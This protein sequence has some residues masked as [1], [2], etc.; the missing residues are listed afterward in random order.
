VNV[1]AHGSGLVMADAKST[2]PAGRASRA[3]PATAAV[4]DLEA[5]PD[6]VLPLPKQHSMSAMGTGKMPGSEEP[7]RRDLETSIPAELNTVLAFYRNELGKRGW[8]EAAERALV[9]PDQVQ[10]AF[11]APDGPALLKLGRS[12]DE[13]SVKLSQKYPGSAAKANLIP[14]PG[15]ARLVFANMGDG[16]VALSINKQT[17]KIAAGAGGPQSPARPMLDLPP[18]KYPYSVKVAGRP[19]RNDTIEVAA[20]DAWGV[21]FAPSGEALSLQVY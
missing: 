8:K 13:T 5:E 3:P 20:D 15:Q 1:S 11:S 16:E 9:K 21:L 19:V 2:A 10:L 7:F 17:I 14:K 6:S 12:H 4:Q 18:G